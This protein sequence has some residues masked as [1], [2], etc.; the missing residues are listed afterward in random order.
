MKDRCEALVLGI[1]NVLWAD[2]GFGVRLETEDGEEVTPPTEEIGLAKFDLLADRIARIY[3]KGELV[4]MVR[5][6]FDSR[7]DLDLVAGRRRSARRPPEG[8]AGGQEHGR[9]STEA[10]GRYFTISSSVGCG[11]P[12][13]H[14]RWRAR[15]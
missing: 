12:N 13:S 10:G 1:G 6:R 5:L 4:S 14:R 9:E 11:G 3:G 8:A 7:S 15:A 2:E